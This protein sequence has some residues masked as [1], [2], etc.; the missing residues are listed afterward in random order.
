[1]TSEPDPAV[2]ACVAELCALGSRMQQNVIELS[3]LQRQLCGRKIS[4]FAEIGVAKGGMLYWARSFVLPGGSIIAIDDYKEAESPV[5]R[6]RALR[7]M[8]ALRTT[9]E[10]VF[11]EQ[12]SHDAFAQVRAYLHGRTIDH[13]HIDGSHTYDD[14]RAD[15]EAY[16]PLVTRPGG[17]IQLHDINPVGAGPG[18]GVPRYWTELKAQYQHREIIQRGSCACGI[19]IILL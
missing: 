14:V 6:G 13:L 4:V 12:S 5:E 8:A 16:S 18:A 2:E 19:G 7:V 17:I 11:I 9:H 1:M 3:E 10:V 15:F